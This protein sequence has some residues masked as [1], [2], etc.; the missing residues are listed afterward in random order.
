M[1]ICLARLKIA[2]WGNLPQPRDL[3]RRMAPG[4]KPS[5]ASCQGQIVLADGT[6]ASPEKG[7]PRGSPPPGRPIT[8]YSSAEDLALAASKK[9]HGYPRAGDSAP[10]L[11]LMPGIET[12]DATSVDTNLRGHSYF[13]EARS[14]LSDIFYLVR[15]NQRA[16]QRF[17]LRGVDIEGG[18]Y[19]EFKQ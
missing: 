5:T 8:L 1:C 2:L 13:A 18:R 15:S 6:Q 17:G 7:P 19:W 11:I 9:V 10:G 14:V 16:D 4:A 3:K 12:I